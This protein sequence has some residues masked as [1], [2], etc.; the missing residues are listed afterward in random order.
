MKLNACCSICQTNK[1]KNVLAY[2][3]LYINAYPLPLA[4]AQVFSYSANGHTNVYAANPA[5]LF[6]SM[7]LLNL[8][9]PTS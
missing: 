5:A 2:N 1:Q 7:Y 9:R 4:F 8:Y 6:V 3:W